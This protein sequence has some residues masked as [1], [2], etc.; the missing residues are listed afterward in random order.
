MRRDEVEWAWRWVEPI[1]DAWE[2]LGDAPKPYPA[3]SWGPAASTALIAR[4]GRS[5]REETA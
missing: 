1:H 5:W 3:G 2:A 4:D